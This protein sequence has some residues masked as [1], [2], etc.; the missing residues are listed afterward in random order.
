MW[1]MGRRP[2]RYSC[3]IV[4]VGL[5]TSPRKPRPL[6]RPF[7]SWVFPAPRTPCRAKISPPTRFVA[8]LSPKACAA[9]TLFKMVKPMCN[10]RLPQTHAAR[11]HDSHTMQ[12]RGE[13]PLLF[14]SFYV[15]RLYGKKEF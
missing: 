14:Q 11:P 4:K 7:A 9:S 6:A 1:Y 3:T 15:R 13:W 12:G 2:P 8:Q 10:K 5:V